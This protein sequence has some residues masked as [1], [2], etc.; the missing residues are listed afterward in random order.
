M[1]ELQGG[2]SE[3]FSDISLECGLRDGATHHGR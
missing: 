3:G 2:V 1:W